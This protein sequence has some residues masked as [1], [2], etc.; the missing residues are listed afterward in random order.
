MVSQATAPK[1]T[2]AYGAGFLEALAYS[3][4]PTGGRIARA[5]RSRIAGHRSAGGSRQRWTR[6]RRCDRRSR[7]RPRKRL[8]SGGEAPGCVGRKCSSDR[9]CGPDLIEFATAARAR[10]SRLAVRASDAVGGALVTGL[11]KASDPVGL[12]GWRQPT[13]RQ[14]TADAKPVPPRPLP[15]RRR[16]RG[17]PSGASPT[18]RATA[19]VRSRDRAGADAGA[20]RSPPNHQSRLAPRNPKESTADLYRPRTCCHCAGRCEAATAASCPRKSERISSVR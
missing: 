12:G 9:R 18:R 5:L 1:P 20:G 7:H 8:H 11:S 6:S 14:R 10:T 15:R 13:G 19:G 3:N 17:R 4:V 16:I 2:F